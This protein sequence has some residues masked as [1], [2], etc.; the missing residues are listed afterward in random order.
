MS[1]DIRIVSPRS[2]D[3]CGNLYETWTRCISGE[4]V[5]N[6]AHTSF[7][8]STGRR[9]A[10]RRCRRCGLSLE[11]RRPARAAAD[12]EAGR[13]LDPAERTYQAGRV[14]AG[15]GGARGDRG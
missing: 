6:D 5:S 15:C 10:D 14:R 13:L 4:K 8:G 7:A 1:D 2:I 9:D 12:Q 11:A 3:P